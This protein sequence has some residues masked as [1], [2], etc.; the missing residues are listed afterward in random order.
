MRLSQNSE[1]APGPRDIVDPLVAIWA[2]L[3]TLVLVWVLLS[4]GSSGSMITNEH[5][6]RMSTATQVSVQATR[7]AQLTRLSPTP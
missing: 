5:A 3:A 7:I 6:A 4:W 2:F 1:R